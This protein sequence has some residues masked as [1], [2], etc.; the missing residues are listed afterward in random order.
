MIKKIA[1]RGFTLI[2]LLVVI[3]IIGIL[4]GVVLTSL[5][6]ARTS[7]ADSKVKSQL[8]SVRAEAEIFATNSGGTYTNLCS[9]A[10]VVAL[11]AAPVSGTCTVLSSG[12][13]WVVSAPTT[14]TTGRWCV[15]HTGAS[16]QITTTTHP[17]AA[18]PAS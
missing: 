4:A 3:A 5:G 13:G 8:A 12:A 10:Q 6:S 2:E 14:G 9:N 11:M 15:D 7:A 16:R 1:Q 18:C 17:T